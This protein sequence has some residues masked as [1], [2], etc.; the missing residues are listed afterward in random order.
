MPKALKYVVF[1]LTIIC[2]IALF[3]AAALGIFFAIS[4]VSEAWSI[5]HEDYVNQD[6][7]NDWDLARGA[8][9]GT[10]AAIFGDA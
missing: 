4:P 10:F 6:E 5:I 2:L 8:I 7:V 3:L 9:G 1:S